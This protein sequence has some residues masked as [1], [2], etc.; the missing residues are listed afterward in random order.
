M[1]SVNVFTE[2]PSAQFARSAR[3]SFS[4][5]PSLCRLA[6]T[7]RMGCTWVGKTLNSVAIRR[8][9]TPDSICCTSRGHCCGH[10]PHV[11]QR[12]MSSFSISVIPKLASRMTFRMLNVVT[13]FQGHTVSHRPHW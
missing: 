1:S 10:R 9:A 12:Q 13:R 5:L 11:V 3:F 6:L 7:P 8:R 2:R 4:G